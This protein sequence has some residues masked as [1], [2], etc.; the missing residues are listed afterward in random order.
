V[1]RRLPLRV[2]ADKVVAEMG[3]VEKAGAKKALSKKVVDEKL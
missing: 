2:G 3:F 1:L